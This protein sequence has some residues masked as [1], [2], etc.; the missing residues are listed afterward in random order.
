VSKLLDNPTKEVPKRSLIVAVL[1]TVVIVVLSFFLTFSVMYVLLF[2][3]LACLANLFAF[4]MIVLHSRDMIRKQ[5]EGKKANVMPNLLTRYAVYLAVIIAAYV[6]GELPGLMAA[7]VGVQLAS[8]T[9]KI[10][11]FFSGGD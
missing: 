11:R 3:W 4:R 7:F 8:I 9:I 1:L 5:E 2:F 6:Y 10:D